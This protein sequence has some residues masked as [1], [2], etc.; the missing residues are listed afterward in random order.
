VKPK[1]VIFD[2]FGTLL[3]IASLATAAEKFTRDPAALVATWREKQLAYAFAATIM[4]RYEDFDALTDR[5]LSFAAQRHGLDMGER[6]WEALGSEW[7]RMRPFVDVPAALTLLRERGYACGVLTNGTPKTAAA[8][9]AASGLT[10]E[11]ETTLS[12]ESVRVYKPD[13]RVYDLACAHYGVPAS[14]LVFVTANGWDATGAAEF[15]L[16][17]IWCNRAQAPAETFGA[18]PAAVVRTLTEI[19]ALLDG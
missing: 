10:G 3:D 1:A 2:L 4:G 13:R 8:A 12:V 9:L 16:H 14:E 17:V 19:P 6:A 15:G 7:E 5:A 11:I 18:A